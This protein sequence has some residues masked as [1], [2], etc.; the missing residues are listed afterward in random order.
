MRDGDDHGIRASG[1]G[2]H[3]LL[4]ARERDP[5]APRDD[6][7]V[8]TTEHAQ[9]LTVELAGIGG[10]EPA[11]AA[12]VR[13]TLLGELRVVEVAVGDRRAAQLHFAVDDAHARPA[14]RSAVVDAFAA[15][16]TRA[17]AAHDADA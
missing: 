16:F 11:D 7:V 4:D 17:V 1:L 14:D 15:R 12:V 3:H 8:A 2:A 6:D 10:A 13:E 5:H 9:R